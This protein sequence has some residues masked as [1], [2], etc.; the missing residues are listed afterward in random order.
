[1]NYYNENQSISE[2][3]ENWLYDQSSMSKKEKE[4]FLSYYFSYVKNFGQNIKNQYS[5]QSIDVI[6]LID[7]SNEPPALL[8]VGSGCGTESL[9]FAL[10]GANVTGIDI[11]SNRLRVAKKRLKII[12]DQGHKINLKYVQSNIND[13]NGKFDIIY[14]SQTFHHI[15]PRLD[16][17]KKLSNLL[18]VGGH[19]VISE[20]NGWNPLLQIS[21]IKKRGFETIKEFEYNGKMVKYGNERI[22]IPYSIKKLFLREGIVPVK[23][24]YF[25]IFKNSPIF[26]NNFCIMLEKFFPRKLFPVFTHFNFVGKKN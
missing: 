5:R 12:E 2:F 16:C 1:M 23:S 18:K 19:L 11:R 7:K 20:A 10:K 8:E 15:E 22:T 9:F 14:M 6:E 13:V 25:R 4:I 26:E 3:L 21:L 17:V 24:N